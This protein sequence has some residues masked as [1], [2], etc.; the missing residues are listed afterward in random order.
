MEIELP[1]G[2]NLLRWT[3]SKIKGAYNLSGGNAGEDRAWLDNVKW[4][5]ETAADFS[6]VVVTDT[7]TPADLGITEGAFADEKPGSESLVKLVAWAQANGKTVSDVNAMA[8][9]EAGD[10]VGDDAA[11][12]LL[13][14]AP[15][16]IAAESANFKVTSISMDGAGNVTL[17][18]ADGSAYGNGKVDV[19]YSET[20]GGEY[21][22][23]KPKGGSCFIKLYLVK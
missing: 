16:E 17:S 6:E 22:T 20:P 9:S 2:T 13:D 12:Y 21:T 15:G 11:A 3:F 5:P 8:F 7:T 4:T 19:R 14:C 18:P 1:E 23:E 10:P